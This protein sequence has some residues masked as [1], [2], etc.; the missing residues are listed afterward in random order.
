MYSAV[1]QRGC[2]NR[3]SFEVEVANADSIL[4]D[5]TRVHNQGPVEFYIVCK[6]V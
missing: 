2:A 6:I 1:P 4:K 5:V 3:K